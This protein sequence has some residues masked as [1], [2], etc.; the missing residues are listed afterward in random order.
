MTAWLSYLCLFLRECWQ[1]ISIH[2]KAS[3]SFFVFPQM[4]L[5]QTSLSISKVQLPTH[6][7]MPG[8][9]GVILDYEFSFWPHIQLLSKE[10]PRVCTPYGR[11]EQPHPSEYPH[12]ERYC[13]RVP[14]GCNIAGEPAQL[15]WR[16]IV[17]IDLSSLRYPAMDHYMGE[18]LQYKY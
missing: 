17:R 1:C 10:L 7:C 13:R 3:A 14:H 6:P 11:S 5:P 9:W 16:F 12:C 18:R 2:P 15:H 8:C 4:P